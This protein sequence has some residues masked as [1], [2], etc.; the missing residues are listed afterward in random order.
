MLD[1]VN[2]T[3]DKFFT[4]YYPH[5]VRFAKS[6]VRDIGIAEDFTT[7]AFMAYWDN[8][9]NLA[10]DSNVEAY[11]LTVIKNKCLNHLKQVERRSEILTDIGDCARWELDFRVNSLEAC[12][13]KEIFSAEIQKIVKNTMSKMPRRTLE[14]FLLSRHKN[15][16]YK[17]IAEKFDITPKGVEF[18]ISKALSLLRLNLKDYLSL[19]IAFFFMLNK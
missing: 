8:R 12:D 4:I 6:Y 11:I 10:P 5:F 17:E 1:S 14:I 3:F 18:H 19:W 7:E 13:P 16:P 2:M 9:A 15:M